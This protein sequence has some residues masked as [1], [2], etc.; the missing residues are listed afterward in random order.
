MADYG[1]AVGSALG[2]IGSSIGG[3]FGAIGASVGGL[4][5]GAIQSA[6]GVAPIVLVAAVA[7]VLFAVLFLRRSIQ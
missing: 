6:S 7:L 2:G 1:S 5:G 3:M 4:V